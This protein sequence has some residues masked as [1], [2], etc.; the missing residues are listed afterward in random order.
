MRLWHESLLHLLPNLQLLGQHRECCALR[1]LGWGRPHSTVNY[2]FDHPYEYLYVYH[3]KVLREML[4]RG[5]EPHPTWYRMTYRGA[6]APHIIY[7]SKENE[8]SLR[9]LV[10]DWVDFP[11][12]YY[13]P[14][15]DLSIVE[16][17]KPEV[18]VYPEHNDQYLRECL[19]NLSRKGIHLEVYHGKVEET[20]LR[21]GLSG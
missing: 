14:N 16:L 9:A 12:G 15:P 21:E 3:L 11:D 19:D 2:V 13:K 7:Y 5:Y 20:S 10:L 8:E 1:G 4:N 6:K 17:A 18:L